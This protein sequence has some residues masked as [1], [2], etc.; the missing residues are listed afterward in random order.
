MMVA[1][2]EGGRELGKMG[3]GEQERHGTAKSRE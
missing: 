1:R 2:G 3:G